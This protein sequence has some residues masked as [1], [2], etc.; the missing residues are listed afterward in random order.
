VRILLSDVAH[1]AYGPALTDRFPSA[2]FA[3]IARDGTFITADGGVTDSP[4]EIAWATHDLFVEGPFQDFFR[5][6]A[7]SSSLRW[8]QSSGAGVD[9]PFFIDLIERGVA[10]TTSFAASVPIAEFVIRSVLQ[11]FQK[12]ERWEGQR[13]KRSWRH[14]F[15]REAADTEWLVVGMG[16]IGTEVATRA[17]AFGARIVGV[18]RHPT[19]GEPVDAMISPAD[20]L[21]AATSADVVV[22]S[23]PATAETHHL[24]DK[25]FLSMMKHN[26]VFVNIARGSLVDQDA[27]IAAL[28]TGCPELA[29]LDTVAIEPPPRDSV[30]WTHPR[31]VL[32]PHNSFAGDGTAKRNAT[33]FM[34][35]LDR[36]IAGDPLMN[37][38]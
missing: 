27:L 37:R 11:C 38:V 24:I 20:L 7:A 19:G 10:V 29:I 32:T 8:F 16:S 30:L 22:V 34:D 1:R 4:V 9:S 17:R 28:D 35:N 14:H 2:S 25:S 26:S 15:F 21:V 31:V 13:A 3:V 23:A 36:Y 6:S 5:V 12:P 18:R 33:L